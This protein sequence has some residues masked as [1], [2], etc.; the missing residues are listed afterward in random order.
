EVGERF[1]LNLHH[2]I[3]M[4]PTDVK[5]KDHTVSE[6]V[7]KGYKLGE[8]VIRVARVNIFEYKEE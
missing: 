1:D 4:I 5:E 6:V 8:R 2:S 7:Q 3:E